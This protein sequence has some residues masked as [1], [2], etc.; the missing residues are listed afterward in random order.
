MANLTDSAYDQEIERHYRHNFIVNV[1]DFS[2]YSLGLSFASLMTILPLYLSHLTTSTVLIGLI[3]A[4]A[5]TGWTLPQLFTANYVERLPRKKPYILAVS[6]NDRLPFL[7]LAL[8]IL[9]RPQAPAGASIVLFFVLLAMHSFSGGL[10]GVA[11]QD[12]IAKLI[13]LRRRGIF[14]GLANSLGGILG[15]LGAYASR[16]ILERHPFPTGFATCFLIAF[17]AMAC[18]WC[19]L[20]L[21]KEPARSGT[22]PRISHREYWR[23]LPTVLRQDRNFVLYLLSR[24]VIIL[25]SIASGFITVYAV[26]RFRLP[27]QTVGWFTAAL[28]I[29]QA[30]SNPLLGHLGD[31]RGHKLVIELSTM[32]WALAMVVALAANSVAWF[33]LVFALTGCATSGWL[34]SM[35]ITF[36]FCASEDRPTYIGLTS[37]LLWPFLTLTPLLG[38]WLAGSLGY[39]GLFAI[40]LVASMAGCALLHGAVREPREDGKR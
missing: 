19:F 17:A 2:F 20:S 39:R 7:I 23:R 24:A 33:L 36:E 16:P 14:F 35:S 30:I 21:A 8:S 32:I 29:G 34:S 3:P 25:G 11:W 10:V 22:K 26:S 6:I 4:L 37:T 12:Y 15:V 1:L 31:R 40:S 18:S 13:P 9:W 27:D 28:L 5:N 38:G